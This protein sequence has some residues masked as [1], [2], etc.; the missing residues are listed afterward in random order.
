ML[1][2][3]LDSEFLNLGNLHS[4]GIEPFEIFSK[5]SFCYIENSQGSQTNVRESKIEN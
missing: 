3:N 2:L 4:E 5:G 1:S